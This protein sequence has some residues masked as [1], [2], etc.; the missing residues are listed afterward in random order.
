MQEK[1]SEGND[2]RKMSRREKIVEVLFLL[3]VFVFF[4]IWA[5]KTPFNASPDEEMRYRVSEYIINHGAL[6]DG[7]D[8][9]IRNPNW[10]ISYALSLIHI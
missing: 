5:A 2:I 9:E 1:K 7:R 8:P 3:A 6:P 10:G 4:Y